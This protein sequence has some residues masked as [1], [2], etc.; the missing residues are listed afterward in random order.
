[1][2][3]TPAQCR[4]CTGAAA[5]LFRRLSPDQWARLRDAVVAHVYQA[6]DVVFHEGTPPLAVYCVRSGALKLYRRMN[7]GDE[8]VVG[9]RG[10]GDLVGLRA[11]LA[12]LPYW[13][14]AAA[15]ERAIIC[16]IP[17]QGFLELIG[18]NIG[19]A[20]QLLTRLACESR[21]VETQLVE[22]CQEHVGKRT[23][24]FLARVAQGSV[25]LASSRPGHEI[26]I[27]REDMARLI[28]TTPET[29]SRTLHGL[30]KRGIL[31]LDRKHIKVRNLEALLKLAE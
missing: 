14:T 9:I 3:S 18:E 27:H 31:E 20:F 24:R 4:S 7:H 23:A 26:S 28:G 16:A 22:R 8:V 29:L 17:A 1:M 12:G 6:A 25:P 15:L 5:E 19:L 11:V 2:M 13:T 30:S 10:A 21:S